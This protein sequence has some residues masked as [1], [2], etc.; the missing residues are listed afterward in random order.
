[1]LK[2]DI[3]IL[4]S[5][6]FSAFFSGL[7][8]AFVSSNRLFLEIQKKQTGFNAKF[9]KRCTDNPSEFIASMLLG[10]N[11]SLVI[12]GI[13]MSERLLD[14]FFP[15][16]KN[17]LNFKLDVLFYQTIISTLIILISA[18]FLPKVFFRIY[19]HKLIT[20]F[21]I[22]AAIFFFIF[23]PITS[24]IIRLNDWILK[25]FFNIKTNTAQL[26]FS[27]LELGDFIE[28]QIENSKNKDEIDT[29]IKFFQNALDFSDLRSRE[30]MVPRTEIIA[31]D[32]DTSYDDLKSLFIE[33]GFSR[34]PVYKKSIDDIIGYVHSFE[35]FKQPK[36]IKEIILPVSYVPEPMPINKVLE[37]LSKQRRSM[38][39]VLDE[40]GGTSGLITVEDI[41]EEL[42]GEIE[43]EHDQVEHVEKIISK[44][45]F[46]F[47]TRLDVDYINKTYKLGII[48]NEFY[49]T[50]GGWIVF[51]T[52]EIPKEEEEILIEK[53]K[54]KILKTTST[55][56]QK[57][58]LE[59]IDNY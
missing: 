43:D 1:M 4:L 19:S 34:I 21:A 30:T 51:H 13:F 6:I 47:S 54:V 33:T 44:K 50:L 31:V 10:N 12:Y 17:N 2:I 15:A 8:M 52:G 7:E 11:I 23:R 35:M 16:I 14:I 41:I 38:A 5:L 3:I 56:I 29:E 49:E 28:E 32:I 9:L 57:I 46:E 25:L 22:P 36:T 18:E 53:F 48:E 27:K 26:S 58:L 42:F 59:I 24:F 37:L 39:I 20:F 40:Y 45:Q 55:K